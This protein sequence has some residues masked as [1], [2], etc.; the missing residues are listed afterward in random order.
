MQSVMDHFNKMNGDNVLP[1]GMS[2]V[3]LGAKFPNLTEQ[4]T[5]YPCVHLLNHLS[6]GILAPE[7]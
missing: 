2:H 1:V 6:Y 5:P 7:N 3:S 4:R